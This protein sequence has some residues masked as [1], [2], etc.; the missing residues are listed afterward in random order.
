MHKEKDRDCG[1]WKG[2]LDREDDVPVS[3]LSDRD[4]MPVEPTA[5]KPPAECG[6]VSPVV[7]L[8]GGGVCVL[9]I[10]LLIVLIVVL[11]LRHHGNLEHD[12]SLQSGYYRHVIS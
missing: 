12:G 9:Y 3:L 5:A 7:L 2:D 8:G 4:A 10:V 11:Y 6:S 1:K